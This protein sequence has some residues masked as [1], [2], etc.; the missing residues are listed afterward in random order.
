[1]LPQDDWERSL[2]AMDVQQGLAAMGMRGGSEPTLQH[3]RGVRPLDLH[4]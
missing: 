2:M 4:A 1:M 3:D